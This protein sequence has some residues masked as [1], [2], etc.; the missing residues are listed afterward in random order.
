M[1]FQEMMEQLKKEYIQA[2]PNRV[3]EIRRKLTAIDTS[4]LRED[5]HKLKG[6]GKT[7]GVPEIT[8]LAEVVERICAGKPKEVVGAV[9]PEA[10]DLLSLIHD[11]RTS[12]RS[13]DI[14]LDERFHKIKDLAN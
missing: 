6:T 7:Y 11:H 9:V 4:S 2:L 5:F 13:F 8:L 1:S 12:Q 14:E 10:L 3:D